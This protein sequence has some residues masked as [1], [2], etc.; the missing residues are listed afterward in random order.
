[1]RRS[2]FF[3]ATLTCLMRTDPLPADEGMW[4]F[5]NPPKD[6]LR[7]K[8]GFRADREMARTRAEGVG[9]LQHQRGSGSFISAD[10]LVMTNHHVG[11]SR[12]SEATSSAGKDYV[13]DGFHAQDPRRGVQVR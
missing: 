10:G 7:K 6:F 1:M 5:N 9:S 12:P 11:L 13:K 8:Y 3:L 2:L 4:L